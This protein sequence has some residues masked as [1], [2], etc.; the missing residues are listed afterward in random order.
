MHC[1]GARVYAWGACCRNSILCMTCFLGVCDAQGKTY[2]FASL[3]CLAAY[4]GYTSM[5]QHASACMYQPAS[6]RVSMHQYAPACSACSI[7]HQYASAYIR[8]SHEGYKIIC[9]MNMLRTK[10]Y[11]S[12][13]KVYE[14]DIK[15]MRMMVEKD[16]VSISD[17]P[18]SI[19]MHQHA[20]ITA[21]ASVCSSMHQHA[22]V[23]ISMHQ[24]APVRI[25]I[26]HHHSL[27]TACINISRSRCSMQCGVLTT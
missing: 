22:S 15:Y 24:H 2:G 23:C 12:A 5:R 20:C 7:V 14:I 13:I 25:I 27:Y 18:V 11:N 17:G 16:I 9:N 6:A 8:I 3:A 4:Q 19:S 21:H 1:R 10:V 26:M